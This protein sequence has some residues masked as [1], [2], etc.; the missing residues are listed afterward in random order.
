MFKLVF[1]DN[2]S[3]I[4]WM[5]QQAIE[6]GFDLDGSPFVL[7]GN[8]CQPM[9]TGVSIFEYKLISAFLPSEFEQMVQQMELDKWFLDGNA[10]D[11]NGS[12]FQWMLRSKASGVNVERASDFVGLGLPGGEVTTPVPSFNMVERVQVLGKLSF[13]NFSFGGVK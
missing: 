3:L 7:A 8:F 9:H 6:E 10:V 5:V 1:T 2:P 11:W 13:S 4:E 12:T